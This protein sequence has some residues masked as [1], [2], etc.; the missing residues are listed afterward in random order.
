MKEGEIDE[1]KTN[2]ETVIFTKRKEMMNMDKLI[3]GAGFI[4]MMIGVALMD[5]ESVAIPMAMTILGLAL[6]YAM[7]HDGVDFHKRK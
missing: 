1:K 6:I 5:S 4:L 2:M 3:G 7:S